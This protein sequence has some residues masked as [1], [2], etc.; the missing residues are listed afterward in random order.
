MTVRTFVRYKYPGIIVPEESFR[1]IKQRD[2]VETAQTAPKGVYAFQ[3]YDV[4]YA[5]I[6]GIDMSSAI[7]NESPTYFING[8]K[9]SLADVKR[10]MP[11]KTILISNMECNHWDHV[12]RTQMGNITPMDDG[13]VIVRYFPTGGGHWLV[14]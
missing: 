4:H 13:D 6:D 8:E 11:D 12:V 10:D 1:E 5:T 9:L 14:S 7:V 2:P 3:F